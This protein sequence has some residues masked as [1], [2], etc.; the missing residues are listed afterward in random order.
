MADGSM[1]PATQGTATALAEA[2]AGGRRGRRQ[3]V[4]RVKNKVTGSKGPV[5]GVRLS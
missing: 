5:N 2:E 4:H 3:A 1:G